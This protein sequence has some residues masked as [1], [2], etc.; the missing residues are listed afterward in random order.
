MP[1]INKYKCNKCGFALPEGWGGYAY[2]E[3]EKGKR[4]IVPHPMEMD[5]FFGPMRFSL[6]GDFKPRKRKKGIEDT[7]GFNSS[8]ACFDCLKQ[9]YLDIGNDE[10]A[11]SSWRYFYGAIK[12]KDERKC[13]FCGSRNV[14]TTLELIGNICPKCKNGIIKEIETGVIC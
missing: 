2:T 10:K 5:V 14:K 1:S 4:E 3:E 11:T 13:P 6:F 7:T 12:R 9:F 8:C